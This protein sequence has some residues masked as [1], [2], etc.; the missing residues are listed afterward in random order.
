MDR[1]RAV[2]G[3]MGDQSLAK[4][5]TNDR[6]AAVALKERRR[7]VIAHREMPLSPMDVTAYKLLTD[8]GAIV[9]P[10]NPGYYLNPTSVGEVIDFVAAK[11]LD[12]VGVKH[13]LS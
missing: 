7:L 5:F 8:A 2:R 1:A 4:Q 13:T 9:C 3:E 11:L 12:L 10:A 6:A